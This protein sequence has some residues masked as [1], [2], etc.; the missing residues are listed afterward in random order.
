[1]KSLNVTTKT[2]DLRILLCLKL[3]TQGHIGKTISIHGLPRSSQTP[4]RP[5]DE[6]G[7][8]IIIPHSYWWCPRG[9][10][11]STCGPTLTDKCFISYH[12]QLETIIIQHHQNIILHENIEQKDTRRSYSRHQT[13]VIYVIYIYSSYSPDIFPWFSP[14]QKPMAEDLP[15]DLQSSAP[16]TCWAPHGALP[17]HRAQCG[18]SC[19][20]WCCTCPGGRGMCGGWMEL[21]MTIWISM[22]NIY[23]YILMI[24]TY[25]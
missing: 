14:G 7:L 8:R 22:N 21:D 20:P 25:I 3:W 15:M 17:S 10:H 16:C 4:S 6:N 18:A 13:Y 5:H 19:C 11:S 12:P 9:W 2:A 1:M 23:I 24:L